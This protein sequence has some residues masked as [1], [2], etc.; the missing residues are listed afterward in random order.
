MGLLL[1]GDYLGQTFCRV[2]SFQRNTFRRRI[3]VCYLI[4]IAP[5]P[6]SCT[7][8]F[9]ISYGIKQQHQPQKDYSCSCLTQMYIRFTS[10]QICNDGTSSQLQSSNMVEVCTRKIIDLLKMCDI[11]NKS[12]F[13]CSYLLKKRR[14]CYNHN[15]QN[16]EIGNN[17]F[18]HDPLSF[19]PNGITYLAEIHVKLDSRGR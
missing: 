18:H 14:I 15:I 19:T 10:C 2:A 16:G 3:I 7:F 12:V 8:I 4:F 1:R 9:T 11:M 5:H 17:E 13:L 6:F